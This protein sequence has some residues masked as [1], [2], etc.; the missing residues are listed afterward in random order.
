VLC[1]SADVQP[2][3]SSGKWGACP[4]FSIVLVWH[5]MGWRVGRVGELACCL[6]SVGPLFKHRGQ[7][8]PC[9]GQHSQLCCRLLPCTLCQAR[10]RLQGGHLQC[11]WVCR[12]A[13]VGES[14]GRTQPLEVHIQ[15]WGAQVYP[16]G[17]ASR[18]WLASVLAAAAC[19]LSS[20]H[21]V[22]SMLPPPPSSYYP[23]FLTP[24]SHRNL[25]SQWGG[26]GSF[27]QLDAAPTHPPTHPRGAPT[28]PLNPVARLLPQLYP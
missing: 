13:R 23:P 26:G 7:G 6:H 12:P 16:A 27:H 18:G 2:C 25:F 8:W 1:C 11:G 10:N 19:L 22:A 4:K 14:G 28:P 20:C 21:S 15:L 3:S 17:A 5:V 24:T 9:A